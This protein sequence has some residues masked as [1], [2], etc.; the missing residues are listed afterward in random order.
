MCRTDSHA[1]RS[2]LK[3]VLKVH[4]DLLPMD[5]QGKVMI[6]FATQAGKKWGSVQ[7]YKSAVSAIHRLRGWAPPPFDELGPFFVGLKKRCD[8]TVQGKEAISA[9]LMLN[10]SYYW[11]KTGTLAAL[12]NNFTAV[13]QFYAM[14][15]VSEVLALTREQIVDKGVGQGFVLSIVRQKNDPYG[16]GM[17]IPLPEVTAGGVPVGLIFRAFL[18]STASLQ[19]QLVRWAAALRRTPASGA[20]AP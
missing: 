9:H 18:A 16:R 19:G 5:N 15:R 8:N 20:T 12:R 1:T 17:D 6:F 14:R 11:V 4:P 13:V 2:Y 3:H 7:A 10:L